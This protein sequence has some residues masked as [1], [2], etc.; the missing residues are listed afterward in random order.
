MKRIVSA[1]L[2]IG[3]FFSTIGLVAAED[4]GTEVGQKAPDFKLIT[5]DGETVQLSDFKGKRVLL[6]FWASWCPPCREEMPDLE[7]F[8]QDKDA[9][10]LAVNLTNMEMNKKTV[11][12]FIE[13][14]GLTF[15]VLMDEEGQVSRLYR[16]SPIPTTYMIDTKGIIGQRVYGPLNYEQMITEYEKMN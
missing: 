10:V 8:Y 11:N 14:Y 13:T 1:L 15:P 9:V 16:I 3:V 2:F 6:N 7:R 5:S 4:I 12:E